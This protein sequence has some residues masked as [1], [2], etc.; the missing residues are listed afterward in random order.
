MLNGAAPF[1]RDRLAGA[2]PDPEVREARVE[3][4]RAALAGRLAESAPAA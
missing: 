1:I 2:E 3:G 4:P